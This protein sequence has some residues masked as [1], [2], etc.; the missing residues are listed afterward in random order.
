M[1]TVV[2]VTTEAGPPDRARL[3]ELIGQALAGAGDA[4]AGVVSLLALD[5]AP[6]AGFGPV[7][8]AG[9]AGTLALIQALDDAGVGAPLWVAT[10]GAVA[11]GPGEDLPSP[12]Q[13]QVWGLGRVA[14]LEHPDRWGGL[15]DLPPVWDEQAGARLCAVLSGSLGEDQVAIRPAGIMARRLVRAPLPRRREAGWRPRGTVLITGGTG[16]IGGHVARWAAGR[17]RGAGAACQPV[18]PGRARRG[19][20]G[21][22]AGRCRDTW[23]S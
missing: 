21:R 2:T 14:G 19:G 9:L 18:R 11:A 10:R 3:A 6:V 23:R 4:P 17:G 8:P 22:R 1:I 15:V 13:A 16:A 12:V 7:V 5:E 20:A